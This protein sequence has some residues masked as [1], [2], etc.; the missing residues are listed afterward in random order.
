MEQN[1]AILVGLSDAARR[2]GLGLS[3]LKVL[4]QRADLRSIRVG[5]R[6]LV[7]VAAI[8]EFVARHLA[9]GAGEEFQ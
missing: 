5:K 4:V 6:R 1:D 2:M 8:E 7:P 3:T 9:D